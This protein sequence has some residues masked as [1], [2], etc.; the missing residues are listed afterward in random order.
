MTNEPFA[1][2]NESFDSTMCCLTVQCS[3][4]RLVGHDKRVVGHDKRVVGQTCESF[5]SAMCCFDSAVQRMRVACGTCESHG[6]VTTG[7]ARKTWR[8]WQFLRGGYNTLTAHTCES[9]VRQTTRMSLGNCLKFA[10]F[11]GVG[12]GSLLPINRDPI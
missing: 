3:D 9:F 10:K 4:M 11:S 1:M 6:I 12:L 7:S 5:D 8:T 2:T